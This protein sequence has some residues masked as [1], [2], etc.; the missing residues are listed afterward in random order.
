MG[1]A[2]VMLLRMYCIIKMV[3]QDNVM[4]GVEYS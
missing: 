3:L 2:K 1:F 4:I